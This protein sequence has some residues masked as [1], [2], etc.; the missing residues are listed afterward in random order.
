MSAT[1]SG[2]ASRATVAMNSGLRPLKSIHANP[3]A[4]NA[5]NAIGMIVAGRAMANELASEFQMLLRAPKIW[6]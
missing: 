1:C 5:A 4:A 2:M 3:Y 6:S